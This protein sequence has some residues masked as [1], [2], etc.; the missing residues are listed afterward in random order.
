MKV[1]DQID[2]FEKVLADKS[3]ENIVPCGKDT[4]WEIKGTFENMTVK[5]SLDAS[6]SGHWHGFITDG[7][8]V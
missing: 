4:S 7:I 1:S 2:L 6:A 8:I 3:L 5:P